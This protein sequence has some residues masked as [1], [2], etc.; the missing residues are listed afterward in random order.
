MGASLGA[1]LGVALGTALGASLGVALGTSL[2]LVVGVASEGVVGSVE[3]LGL[4]RR[5]DI[6]WGNNKKQ[7]DEQDVLLGEY[8]INVSSWSKKKNPSPYK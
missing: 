1:S 5:P 7:F 2:G 6:S 3:L 8:T 4:R